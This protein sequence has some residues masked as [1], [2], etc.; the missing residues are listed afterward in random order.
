MSAGVSQVRDAIANLLSS[1]DTL[2][3][4]YRG[5]KNLPGV[6]SSQVTVVRDSTTC[7]RASLALGK[8]RSDMDPNHGAWVIR[9]GDRRFIAFNGVLRGLEHSFL[10][11]VY[12][13]NFT[14]LG[15]FT[16]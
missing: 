13:T 2:A 1:N 4:R 8:I 6:P 12:D 16:M 15:S 14:K 10:F 7:A 5:E 9:V 11:V 3:V